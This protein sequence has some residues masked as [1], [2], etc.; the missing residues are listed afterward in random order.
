MPEWQVRGKKADKIF[1]VT[2]ANIFKILIEVP[3][4]KFRKFRENCATE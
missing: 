3:N 4:N 2:M 1:D